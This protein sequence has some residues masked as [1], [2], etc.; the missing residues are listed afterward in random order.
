[1]ELTAEQIAFI[2]ADIANKGVSLEELSDSLLDHICC[3]IE[4][5]PGSDFQEAYHEALAK[6]GIDGLQKIQEETVY[7]LI[8][9]KQIIMKKTMFILGYVALFL[10]TTGL[11]FK[12]QHWP[13]ASIMLTLGIVL[14]NFGFLPMYFM[15]RYKKAVN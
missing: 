10:S 9:K 4:N 3:T 7:L 8:H 11:L 2:K 5:N 15:A 14:L 1:M 13:G 12:I 6:F